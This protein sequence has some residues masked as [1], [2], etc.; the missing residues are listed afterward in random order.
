MPEE[1]DVERMNLS[2]NENVMCVVRDVMID[3]YRRITHKLSRQLAMR[4][5]RQFLRS[6]GLSGAIRA[7]TYVEPRG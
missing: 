6:R 4:M 2:V 1:K 7:R 3:E 5:R